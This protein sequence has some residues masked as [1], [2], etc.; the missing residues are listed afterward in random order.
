MVWQMTE[1]VPYQNRVAAYSDEEA[2]TKW[3]ADSGQLKPFGTPDQYREELETVLGFP[4]WNCR[5][6][7]SFDGSFGGY[8]A[9]IVCRGYKDEEF[10]D[11]LIEAQFDRGKGS[12]QNH[13][14]KLIL[15]GNLVDADIIV[16]LTDAELGRRF[17]EA[18]A[19]LEPRTDDIT[20]F[21]IQ[22]EVTEPST[23]DPTLSFTRA[24]PKDK[25]EAPSLRALRQR[26]YWTSLVDTAD[27]ESII[28]KGSAPTSGPGHKIGGG[29]PVTGVNPELVIDSQSGEAKVRI[30]ITNTARTDLYAE[31]YDQ[32]DEIERSVAN[33]AIWDWDSSHSTPPYTV[34]IRQD[35]F[36]LTDRS[37]WRRHQRWMESVISRFENEL[38]PL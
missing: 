35:G 22:T 28:A 31:L 20:F 23:G 19:W 33:D 3:L 4:I 2:F 15:Y 13:L 6:E 34:T 16:W 27:D 37:T 10:Q 5:S 25:P 21:I 17:N 30:R 11:V 8:A 12:S 32:R 38:G 7:V 18:V 24:V 29:F 26:R 1:R 14:G 9:D 36:S